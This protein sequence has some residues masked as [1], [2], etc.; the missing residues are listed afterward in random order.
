M[1]RLL[2]HPS[3][4]LEKAWNSLES[5]GFTIVYGSYEDNQTE[6]IIKDSPSLPSFK[7]FDWITSCEPISLPPINWQ[8]Q[9]ELHGHHF[10]DGYIH[11]DLGIH[12]KLKLQPGAGFGDLSHPTTRLMIKM[13]RNN[14]KRKYAFDIGCGSGILS[15]ATAAMGTEIVYGI[16]IS[17]EAIDHSRQNACINELEERCHF[18]LTTEIVE[19]S[20]LSKIVEPVYIFMNMIRT[21]QFFAYS[22]SPFL[23]KLSGELLTSG[24]Q[25]EERAL[26]LDEM[27]KWG[28]KN[29]QEWEEEGWLGFRFFKEG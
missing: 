5:S 1:Y 22:S 28:W 20:F 9:W 19:E 27:K 4:S 7:T 6:L 10:H 13:I 18:F 29:A 14:R 16:D 2:I 8:E 17:S 15:L 3:W 25:I 26:Y 23:H 24:I 12:G 21:E 11:V